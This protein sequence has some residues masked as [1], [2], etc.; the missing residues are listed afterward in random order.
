MCVTEYGWRETVVGHRE[1]GE[2]ISERYALLIILGSRSTNITN[3]E[4]EEVENS[5]PTVAYRNYLF[6][7]LY[8]M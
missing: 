2:E 5:S 6:L 4:K 8:V 3:R 1:L 7:Y